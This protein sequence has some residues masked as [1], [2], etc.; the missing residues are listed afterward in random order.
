MLDLDSRTLPDIQSTPDKRNIAINK[1]GIKD[2][3]FPITVTTRDNGIQ[4]T[5]GDVSMYVALAKEFKGTHLSRFVAILNEDGEAI[6]PANI[7]NIMAKMRNKIGT[8]E[9]FF[10]VSF[11][12]FLSKAAPVSRIRSLVEY[13]AGFSGRQTANGE[14]DLVLT[15]KVPVTTVCPCSKEISD[16]GAHN[17]RSWVTVKVRANDLVWLED[18]IGLVEQCGSCEVYS[19]I[20][21]VDEKYVTEKGYE[22]PKFVE[23]VVRDVTQLLLDDPRIDW[24]TVESDNEE[25]IHNH[26]AYAL[27]EF[28]KRVK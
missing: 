23:D 8:D 24:F 4:H 17:Q 16:Y 25:S 13:K 19:L 18:L 21:R 15:V 11:P 22:N 26:N 1:V 10:E 20:K 14:T 6:D 28:D 3:R 9:A 12:Y 5:V 7:D 2:I 27:I